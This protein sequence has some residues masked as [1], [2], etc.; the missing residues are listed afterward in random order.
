MPKSNKAKLE[1]IVCANFKLLETL[2]NVYFSIDDCSS[3]EISRMTKI[4]WACGN[5]CNDGCGIYRCHVL[6]R[7]KGGGDEAGNYFL[8]C[9]LCHEEQPD[10]LSR[11]LQEEWLRDHETCFARYY[12]VVAELFD[13]LKQIGGE[14]GFTRWC[15]ERTPKKVRDILS[16]G[17]ASAAGWKNGRANAFGL[18]KADLKDFIRNPPK[19]RTK[20][21][22]AI[23]MSLGEP[24]C[25]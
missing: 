24:K 17:Y 16:E 20:L 7:C 21:T 14:E 22:P 2:P 3:T 19:K 25:R 8:L 6:A 1:D 18:L 4:C 12:K 23:S 5:D 15:E 10:G 9:D 11:E 13:E